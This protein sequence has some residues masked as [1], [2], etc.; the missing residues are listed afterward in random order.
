METTKMFKG[1][2]VWSGVLLHGG[3]PSCWV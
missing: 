3:Q 2:Q 1:R